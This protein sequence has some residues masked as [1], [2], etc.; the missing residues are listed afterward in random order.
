MKKCIL[1]IMLAFMLSACGGNETDSAIFIEPQTYTFESAIKAETLTQEESIVFYESFIE[2]IETQYLIETADDLDGFN[3]L[4][5]DN[6]KLALDNLENISYFLIKIPSDCNTYSDYAYH[7]YDGLALEITM[8][9]FRNDSD[10][11][12]PAVVIDAYYV[13]NAQKQP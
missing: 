2:H 9:R 10:T 7:D 3:A 8:D 11:S 4:L 13:F 6:E 1:L 12:C 5:S